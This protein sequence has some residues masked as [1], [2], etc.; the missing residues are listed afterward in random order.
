MTKEEEEEILKA[1][2][3]IS[4][5]LK[6]INVEFNL[7]VNNLKNSINALPNQIDLIIEKEFR[8]IASSINEIEQQLRPL[9][10]SVNDIKE[11]VDALPTKISLKAKHQFKPLAITINL[12]RKLTN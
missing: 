11:S 12:I 2:Q 3:D 8:T 1:I 9:A 5:D 7:D 6:A 4:V 10:C